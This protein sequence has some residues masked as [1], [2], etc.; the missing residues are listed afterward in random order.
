MAWI[1]L[2]KQNL[3]RDGVVWRQVFGPRMIRMHPEQYI[4]LVMAVGCSSLLE[5]VSSISPS[6][7]RHKENPAGP[8]TPYASSNMP[9]NESNLELGVELETWQEVGMH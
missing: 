2:P 4:H 5:Y 9:W 1:T 6:G 3:S 7:C 8:L